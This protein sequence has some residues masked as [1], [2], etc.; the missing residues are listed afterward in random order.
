MPELPEVEAAVQELRQHAVARVV[1]RVRVLHPSLRRRMSA[2][3]RRSLANASVMRVERRGKHQ[4]IHLGDG[5]IL[6]AHFRMNGAWSFGRVGQPLPR[7]ARA[8][9]EFTDGSRIALVDSRALGTLE[10]YAA[11][12]ELAL[13]LGPDAADAGWTAVQLRES[14]A[15]RRAPIKAALLDQRV[16]AGLGNIYVAEALWRARIDPRAP[17]NSLDIRTVR[18]LRKA[19]AAVLARATGARYA[20]GD[21]DRLDVYGRE[22]LPC[23]RCKTRIARMAQAGRSTYYCPSCQGSR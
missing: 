8:V 4:L 23:R 10:V 6:L 16:V 2:A 19:V 15:C 20:D 22:G 13:G 1:A 11:G 3:A 5:R 21:A 7:H 12:V 14:L 18:A 17:S 9:L